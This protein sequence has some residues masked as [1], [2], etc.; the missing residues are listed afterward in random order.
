MRFKNNLPNL[1]FQER[2]LQI[3]K[4]IGEMK[5][6]GLK[7]LKPL[8]FQRNINFSRC[9]ARLSLM[10]RWNYIGAVA[11]TQNREKYYYLK[12]FGRKVLD[13]QGFLYE[14]FSEIKMF[15]LGVLTHTVLIAEIRAKME[16]RH[17]VSFWISEKQL[18]ESYMSHLNSSEAYIPDGFFIDSKGQSFIF[19]FENTQKS[20]KRIEG[21][22]DDMMETMG[23]FSQEHGPCKALI[24]CKTQSVANHYEN[25]PYSRD[26]EIKLL[27]E[28]L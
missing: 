10:S 4:F 22:I 2:D 18:K 3:L 6:V 27:D 28:I 9:R 5:F 15:C 24:V 16:S 20:R 11:S 13:E 23:I 14:E 21:R 1:V 8:F 7:A 19:E 12:K 26:F 25:S 17:E